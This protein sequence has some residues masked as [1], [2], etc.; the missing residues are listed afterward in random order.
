MV[1][2]QEKEFIVKDAPPV[3]YVEVEDQ[4]GGMPEWFANRISID[5]IHDGPFI[6]QKFLVNDAG[7]SFD[8]DRFNINM[9]SSAIGRQLCSGQS[10]IS[11][12]TVFNSTNG[13]MSDGLWP[14]SRL[15]QG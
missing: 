5:V 2:D 6:P 8:L 12:K 7:E 10:R 14:F 9:L 4:N 1:L 3:R 15:Q 11:G 13:S